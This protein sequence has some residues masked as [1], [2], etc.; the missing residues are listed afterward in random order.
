MTR[1]RTILTGLCALVL[2]TIAVSAEAGTLA[3]WRFEGNSGSAVADGTAV[4]NFGT[5]LIDEKVNKVLYTFG[6]GTAPTWEGDGVNELFGSQV[7]LPDALDVAGNGTYNNLGVN[8]RS[9]NF[10]SDTGQ[11]T[12][13]ADD[14]ALDF[15]LNQAFTVEGYMKRD[16]APDSDRRMLSKRGSAFPFP[17]YSA[18]VTSGGYFQFY[19]DTG[20][21]GPVADNLITHD[22]IVVTDNAWHHWAA[23]RSSTGTIRLFVD[24]IEDTDLWV[25]LGSS[26]GLNHDLSN[27]DP[28]Y[29]GVDGR[30]FGHFRP[31]TGY[32]DEI[33]LSDVAL[34]PPEFLNGSGP[35]LPGD[36]EPDGDVDL[37]DYQQLLDN[38]A[39][40]LDGPIGAGH[41][42]NLDFDQDVDLDDFELFKGFYEDFN[43]ITLAESLAVVPE[44]STWILCSLVAG[45][46]ACVRFRRKLPSHSCC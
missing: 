10:S 4:P 2:V 26:T 35:S 45:S 31:Y 7:A 37:D 24:G 3:Y 12:M 5:P 34:T 11:L 43:G 1:V 13:P 36:F 23:T 22:E 41:T 29:V 15:G 17:G 16:G 42:G 19:L 39:I 14:N 8:G 30:D 46:C 25:A 32:L 28:L 33:R 44:P 40:Q 21:A 20:P 38:M 18:I 27:A 6:A 9:V